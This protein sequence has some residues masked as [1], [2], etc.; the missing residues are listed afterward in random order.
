[1]RVKRKENKGPVKQST[2]QRQ[3]SQE[4]REYMQRQIIE[5]RRRKQQ[6]RRKV[7]FEQE[8]KRR[9][10]QDIVKKQKEALYKTKKQQTQQSEVC[11][12]MC[13]ELVP[14]SLLN[15]L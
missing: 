15:M 3:N 1:M 13:Q 4:V 11:I 5:R 6:I 10:V 8:R 12:E 2:A 14:C 9:S 7:E